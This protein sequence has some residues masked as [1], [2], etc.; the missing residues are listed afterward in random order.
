MS[1][2]PDYIYPGQ[3]FDEIA[4]MSVVMPKFPALAYSLSNLPGSRDVAN[5][6]AQAVMISD[7]N[8]YG[9]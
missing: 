1:Y 4:S 2:I 8:P 3:A 7:I 9:E 5:A 6:A